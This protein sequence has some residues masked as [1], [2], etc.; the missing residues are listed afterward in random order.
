ML[1]L[2]TNASR[3]G[4]QYHYM[5]KMDLTSPN[6]DKACLHLNNEMT[7]YFMCGP[8][9]FMD[10]ERQGLINLGVD[11]SR[12]HVSCLLCPHADICPVICLIVFPF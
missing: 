10:A 2:L 11:E 4:S 12:I 7:Q 5:G 1:S 9:G 8:E 6:F 3:F